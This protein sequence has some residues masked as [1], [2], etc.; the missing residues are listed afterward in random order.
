LFGLILAKIFALIYWS[1]K[2]LTKRNLPG[3]GRA[4]DLIKSEQILD[5]KGRKFYFDPRTGRAYGLMIIGQWNEPET[6]VFLGTLLDEIDGALNFVDVGASIGEFVVDMAS[7]HKVAKVIAFEPQ[8]VAAEAIR[9]SCR[10]NGFDKVSIS[11]KMITS[12]GNVGFFFTNDRSPTASHGIDPLGVN[13]RELAQQNIRQVSATTL[14]HELIGLDGSTIILI[15]I[16]GGEQSAIKGGINFIR[17]CNPLLIFE[18]NALSRKSFS[19]KM[20]EDLMGPDY[21]IYRLRSD[22]NVDDDLSRTWNLVAVHRSTEFFD[23]V[24]SLR[25]KL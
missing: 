18:Y 23:I 24:S 5:V 17:R 6:H 9:K 14:D 2:K 21:A 22:G 13:S 4:L 15:D 1:Y 16:E 19:L 20:V 12:N 3:L 11:P 10:L 25:H 8:E 7:H